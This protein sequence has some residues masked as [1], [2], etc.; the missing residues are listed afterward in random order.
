M[1]NAKTPA[2]AI[3]YIEAFP[4]CG[5]LISDVAP[6][7]TAPQSVDGLS[8]LVILSGSAVACVLLVALSLLPCPSAVSRQSHLAQPLEK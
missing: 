7:S 6:L 1:L 8:C 5:A 3:T 2:R 4:C